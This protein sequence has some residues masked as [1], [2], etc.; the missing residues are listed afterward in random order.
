MPS[1]TTQMDREGIM[2]SEISQIETNTIQSH[3]YV[4]FFKIHTY[5]Y[6]Y[7]HT[8]THTQREREREQTGDCQR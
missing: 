5:I 8:H 4:E 3:L 2:L 6:I 1:A 7:R